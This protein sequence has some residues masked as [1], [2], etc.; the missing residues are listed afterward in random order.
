MHI[1]Y[2]FHLGRPQSVSSHQN[3][4]CPSDRT[5][6][7][8][9]HDRRISGQGD[10][11]EKEMAER[12]EDRNRGDGGMHRFAS[13]SWEGRRVYSSVENEKREFATC[14]M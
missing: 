9:D 8:R 14:L 5:F 3:H 1:F 13:G 2:F 10:P 12:A 4:K 7:P 6:S 11:R